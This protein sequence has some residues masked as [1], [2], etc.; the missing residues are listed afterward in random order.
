MEEENGSDQL[1]V[2]LLDPE[3]R[4]RR[5]RRGWWELKGCRVAVEASTGRSMA[6]RRR[7]ND[8]FVRAKE[9]RGRNADV[10]L[11]LSPPI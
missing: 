10:G 4:R 7:E 9:R 11:D 8:G 6:R 5:R 1:G 2:G 3:C